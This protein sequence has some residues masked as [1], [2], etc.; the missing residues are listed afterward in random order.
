M[1]IDGSRPVNF[2]K[3]RLHLSK[4]QTHFSWIFLCKHLNSLLINLPC[5][6]DSINFCSFLDVNIKQLKT[7]ANLSDCSIQASNIYC[8][9]IL[10]FEPPIH[11]IYCPYTQ[12]LWNTWL[13]SHNDTSIMMYFLKDSNSG[14]LHSVLAGVWHFPC[15]ILKNRHN[16]MENG[17]TFTS[18]WKVQVALSAWPYNE[19][20]SVHKLYNHSTVQ[21][22]C[23]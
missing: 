5:L 20:F 23:S 21:L 13:M 4:P 6:R 14:M 17:Y 2:A 22:Q 15:V 9:N 1:G 7:T 8:Y 16:F 10:M 11:F 12:T 3:L 18:R 19:L